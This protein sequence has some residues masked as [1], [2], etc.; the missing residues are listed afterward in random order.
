M[1]FDAGEKTADVG[2]KAGED[3]YAGFVERMGQT[4]ELPGM[5]ARVGEDYLEGANRRGVFVLG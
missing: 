1:D 4:V 5:E 2:N 3:W